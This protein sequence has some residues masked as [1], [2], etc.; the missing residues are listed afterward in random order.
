MVLAFPKATPNWEERGEGKSHDKKIQRNQQFLASPTQLDLG[1]S[2]PVL[3][4][5]LP[6][7]AGKGETSLHILRCFLIPGM[8]QVALTPTRGHPDRA[9]LPSAA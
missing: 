1:T 4:T 7:D 6:L 8:P 2:A 5:S 9:G 3:L